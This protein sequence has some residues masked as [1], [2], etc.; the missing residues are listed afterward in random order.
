MRQISLFQ[1]KKFVFKAFEN[2]EKKDTLQFSMKK[3]SP[4]IKNY[5]MLLNHFY[6]AKLCGE[7]NI[8]VEKDKITFKEGEVANSLNGFF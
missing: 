8:L 6:Q 5:G 7:S 4:M 2:R 3:T 1:A